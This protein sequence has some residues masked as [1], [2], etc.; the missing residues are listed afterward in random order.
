[1]SIQSQSQELKKNLAEELLLKPKNITFFKNELEALKKIMNF[2][3]KAGNVFSVYP[4]ND[5][6]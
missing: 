1:M 6:F 2:C 5:K 3:F 4:N